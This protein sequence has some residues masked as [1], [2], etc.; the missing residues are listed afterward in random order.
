MTYLLL[1]KFKRKTCQHTHWTTPSNSRDCTRTP[2]SSTECR[3][4]D[5]QGPRVINCQLD[6]FSNPRRGSAP[7]WLVLCTTSS[8]VGS[9]SDSRYVIR[10]I[11]TDPPF[12]HLPSSSA[13]WDPP[14]S[15]SNR[16]Q[17]V[18]FHLSGSGCYSLGLVLR[19]WVWLHAIPWVCLQFTMTIREVF[20]SMINVMLSK[21]LDPVAPGLGLDVR[22]WAQVWFQ[23]LNPDLE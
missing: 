1:P 20:T 21:T 8:W 7:A 9:I 5:S 2:R 3:G 17:V 14:Q 12:L 6:Q 18:R 23:E 22:I 10:D 15:C 19:L 4:Y 11:A 16:T 13:L